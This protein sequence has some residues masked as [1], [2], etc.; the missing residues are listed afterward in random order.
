MSEQTDNMVSRLMTYGLDQDEA[1]VYL[2]LLEKRVSTALSL[3]RLLGIGRTKVYRI[4]DRLIDKRLVTQKLDS[5]GF[6]FVAGDPS[7]LKTLLMVRESELM[8]LSQ[9]LPETIDLLS[10]K[11]GID[12][13]GSRILYYRGVEGLSRVNWNVL[14]ARGELLSYEVATADAYMPQKEAEKLR[15]GIVENRIL[16]RTLTNKQRI[17]PFTKVKAMVKNWW[18][19]RWVG[20]K[21]LSIKTDV[22]IYNDIYAVCHYLEKGDVFCFE[23]QNQPLADMNRQI[24][25][26]L[27][28]Q[29]GVMTKIGDEGEVVRK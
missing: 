16:V 20:E 25:E 26:N 11:L 8:S 4:L 5:G 27:W 28:L 19:I 23:M 21:K 10:Q 3:S 12:M 24:F 6:K 13:P 9:Q 7:Q 29:A 1:R 2:E 14:R 15:E 22:F 17:E 18:N